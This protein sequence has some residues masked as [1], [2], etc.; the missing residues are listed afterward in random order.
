MRTPVPVLESVAVSDSFDKAGLGAPFGETVKRSRFRYR[1]GY[2][3][4]K[5][6]EFRGFGFV[7][8]TELGDKYQEQLVTESYLYV[9]RDPVTGADEEILKGKPYRE[10]KRK[11]EDGPILSTIESVWK[12]VWMCQRD[13]LGVAR[14]ILPRC[15]HFGVWTVAN[16]AATI[17]RWM[18]P[19]P[20]NPGQLL[21]ANTP[22][23][24]PAPTWK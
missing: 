19:D 3:D 15:E 12:R 2:Y 17:Y 4:G 7:A 18:F 14:L 13:L 24:I 11:S 9:G 10:V 23:A 1:D 21:P 20:N 8:V 6:R 16:P 22:V 5:E